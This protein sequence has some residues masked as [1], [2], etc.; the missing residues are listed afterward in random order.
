[1]YD[2]YWVIYRCP[3]TSLTPK[4]LGSTDWETGGNGENKD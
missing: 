2:I 3:S 1:M 4:Y